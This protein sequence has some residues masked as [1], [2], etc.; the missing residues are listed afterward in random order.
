MKNGLTLEPSTEKLTDKT[1]AAK[2]DPLSVIIESAQIVTQVHSG[3]Q[4]TTNDKDTPMEVDSEYLR[5]KPDITEGDVDTEINDNF[6]RS[7]KRK[8]KDEGEPR[9]STKAK[10]KQKAT[11]ESEGDNDKSDNE[12]P[13]SDSD[14]SSGS[15]NINEDIIDMSGYPDSLLYF[16]MPFFVHRLP[17]YPPPPDFV[18]PSKPSYIAFAEDKSAFVVHTLLQPRG[19]PA[20]LDKVTRIHL[21]SKL[22]SFFESSPNLA[23]FHP[24]LTALYGLAEEYRVRSAFAFA[25]GSDSE[26]ESEKM[27]PVP[28]AIFSQEGIEEAFARYLGAFEEYMPKED[29]WLYMKL[30][31]GTD[32]LMKFG[33]QQQFLGAFSAVL[34]T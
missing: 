4:P 28:D 3:A 34:N 20:T 1:E 25:S 11:A 23:P 6:D 32:T 12:G 29:N 18:P 9:M 19:G 13:E 15:N 26:D 10:G 17:T 24:L 33:R 31:E 22:P 7:R 14:A 2:E 30:Y 5:T 8:A 27:S 21:A 16:D